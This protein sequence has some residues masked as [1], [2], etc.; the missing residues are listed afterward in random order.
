MGG[1]EAVLAKAKQSF[2]KGDYRWV[3]QVVN[4]VVLADPKNQAARALQADALE[5]LGYQA[6]NGT[7]RNFYLT[8]AMELRQGVR[9]MP[10]ANTASPDTVRAMTLDMFFDYLGVRLNGPKANGKKATINMDFTDTKEKY[11]VT[12]ENS[13]LNYSKDRQAQDADCTVTLTRANLNEIILG[14][15][16]LP[17]LI[18]AGT[19]KVAGNEKALQEVLGLLDTF[20][21]WFDIVT[22]NT[23]PAPAGG[24]E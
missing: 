8:G 10:A 18:T 7:W 3:A 16:R 6:E 24:G 17:Q 5:Q 2:D 20:E 21:F 11:V 9:K 4:H 12:L 15:A 13:V 19:V 14:Q 1:A 23:P 22:A